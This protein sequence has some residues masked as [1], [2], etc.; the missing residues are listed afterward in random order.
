MK[1][2]DWLRHFV[3]GSSFLVVLPFFLGVRWIEDL[4][5]SLNGYAFTAPL[6]FGALNALSAAVA[7]GRGISERT[8]LLWTSQLSA[9]LVIGYLLVGQPYAFTQAR[10]AQQFALVWLSHFVAWNLII[11]GLEQ[12]FA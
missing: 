8:R 10:Y 3:I 9:L 6:F 11:Y 12:L 5:I 4:P 2:A 1:A 7:E